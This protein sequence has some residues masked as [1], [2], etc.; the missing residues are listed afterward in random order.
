MQLYK[1]GKKILL[2]ISEIILDQKYEL[3]LYMLLLISLKNT[4]LSDGKIYAEL[5]TPP[6]PMF[7]RLKKRTP[8]L[9]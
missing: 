9:F 5:L 6:K 4:A 7:K 3:V 2:G 1:K 8:F